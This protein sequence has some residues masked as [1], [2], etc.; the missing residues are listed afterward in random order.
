MV[1]MR[2][3]KPCSGEW[4]SQELETSRQSLIDSLKRN[5]VSQRVWDSLLPQQ[6]RG[7][8]LQT[9]P[10][11]LLIQVGLESPANNTMILGLIPI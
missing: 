3:E 10:F 7:H 2:V 5:P 6:V 4:E 11:P 8:T 9:R 1:V